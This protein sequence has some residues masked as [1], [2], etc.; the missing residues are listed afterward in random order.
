MVSADARPVSPFT[1][2]ETVAIETPALAATVAN[3]TGCCA[4]SR[5]LFM[6]PCSPL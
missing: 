5:F 1:M 6:A 2:R 3:K 4:E